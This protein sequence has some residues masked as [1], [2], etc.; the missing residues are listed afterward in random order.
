M[1][2]DSRNGSPHI[3]STYEGSQSWLHIKI[4]RGMSKIP[5]D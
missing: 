4:T 2:P 1:P 5:N 3:F